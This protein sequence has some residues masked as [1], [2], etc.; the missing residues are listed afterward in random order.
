MGRD[1]FLDGNTFRESHSVAKE[2]F[3]LDRTV[4]F[5]I[6]YGGLKLSYAQVFRSKEFAAQH[7]SHSY[8]SFA[9]SY[10]FRLGDPKGSKELTSNSVKVTLP[11]FGLPLGHCIH[12]ILVRCYIDKALI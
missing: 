4:G 11:A 6:I 1:I 2:S 3:V 5:S 10:T 8:G 12:S 7:H 9:F